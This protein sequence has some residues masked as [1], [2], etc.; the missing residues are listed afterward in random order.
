LRLHD[1][2]TNVLLPV[3]WTFAA[4][5]TLEFANALPFPE[6]HSN[7]QCS[8]TFTF[9]RPIPFDGTVSHCTLVTDGFDAVA[10]LKGVLWNPN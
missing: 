9:E 10:F 4:D 7:A 5:G 2:L 3:D 6:H 8:L 1:V